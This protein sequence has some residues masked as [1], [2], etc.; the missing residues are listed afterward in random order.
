MKCLACGRDVLKHHRFCSHCG[1]PN[2]Y[3]LESIK[4]TQANAEPFSSNDWKHPGSFSSEKPSFRGWS[5]STEPLGFWM[6]LVCVLFP[7]VGIIMYFS[8][9]NTKP[10][11]AKTALWCGL[12]AFVISFFLR[13]SA[14]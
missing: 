6:G 14:R 2:P 7:F 5:P 3:Y 8:W 12:I 9:K 13:M 1:E 4:E 11:A 10:R